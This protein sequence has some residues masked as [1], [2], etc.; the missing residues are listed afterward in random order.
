MG[1][2]RRPSLKRLAR[3]KLRQ[4]KSLEMVLEGKSLSSIADSLGM[5][6]QGVRKL[7]HKG[8]E[9]QS[10]YPSNLTPERV[11]E[12]RILEVE[13]LMTLWEKIQSGLKEIQKRL[14]SNGEKNLD[15]MAFARMTETG[16]KLSER[17]SRLF[18]LDVPQKA[19]IETFSVNLRRTEERVVISFDA[20]VLAPPAEPIPGLSVWR[21]G[22]LVEGAGDGSAATD[23]GFEPNGHVLIAAT[24]ENEPINDPGAFSLNKN[25]TEHSI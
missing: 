2:G 22:Q 8:I 21:D 25:G 13:R 12:L 7:V 14:G 17:V 16:I 18:G 6:V 10:L 3:S 4:K 9:A 11:Q 5:S 24:A 19:V 23:L 1:I 15:A 20:G